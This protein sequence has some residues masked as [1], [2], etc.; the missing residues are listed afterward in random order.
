MKK[1]VLI[2]IL[3][4]AAGVFSAC[5]QTKDDDVLKL[6]KASG[7]GK[8]MEQ[9]MTLIIPQFQEL[10]PD[11]PDAFWA[12]F[13]GKFDTSE[14]IAACVPIY[15]KYYTHDEIKQLITFYESPIGRKLVETAPLISQEAMAIG[16]QWGESL[17]QEIIT[18]LM[19]EGYLNY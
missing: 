5:A 10:F 16:Q 4:A 1:I 8:T 17:A 15:S 7:A 18:E 2:V 14:L 13:A 9:T 19:N 3:A 12:K 6:L 11:I